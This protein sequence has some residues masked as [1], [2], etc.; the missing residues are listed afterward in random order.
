[1]RVIDLMLLTGI[2]RIRG[3]RLA[4]RCPTMSIG[5]KMMK[6]LNT[7]EGDGSPRMRFAPS[8]TGSLH[9]GGARTALRVAQCHV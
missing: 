2:S 8:P 5:G 9:V 6:E 3:W 1:M 7:Y 4:T